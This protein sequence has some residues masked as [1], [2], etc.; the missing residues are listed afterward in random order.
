LNVEAPL[1]PI[2]LVGHGAFGAGLKDAAEMI[3]GGPQECFSA[4][5]LGPEEDPTEFASRVEAALSTLGVAP[6]SPAVVLAD[7]FGASP[8]NAATAL[9]KGRPGLQVL[10]GTNLAML[11]EVLL[12]RGTSDIDGLVGVAV[13][14]GRG[15]IADAGIVVRAAYQRRQSESISGE[16]R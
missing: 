16:L 6:E 4:L 13:E 10:A 11:L 1:I 5:S 2:V 7:L 3:L 14:R 9:L 8:A 12:G 15:A